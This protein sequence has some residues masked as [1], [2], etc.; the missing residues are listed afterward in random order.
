MDLSEKIKR[1]VVEG[2]RLTLPTGETSDGV[3]CITAFH[4][5]FSTRRKAEEETMVSVHISVT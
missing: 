5:I 2:V 1:P 4:F 3:L